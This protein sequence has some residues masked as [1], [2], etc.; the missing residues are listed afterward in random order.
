MTTNKLKLFLLIIL[1]TAVAFS[2]HA[3]ESRW[4]VSAAFIGP[5]DPIYSWWGHVAIIVEDRSSGA[6]RYY[7]YGNFSFDQDSFINNFAM[8]RLYFL[9]MVSNPDPQLRYSSY[10]NRDVTIYKLNIPENRKL[11][12]IR[13]LENDVK[14]ENRIY[15]YDHFYDNCSTRIRDILNTASGGELARAGAA[16]S[17][18]TIR[19]QLRRFTY[20]SPA[21]D[22]LLNFAMKG[23]VDKPASR[24][25]SMFLPN[26]LEDGIATLMIS[27][28]TGGKAP[29]VSTKKIYNQAEGRTAIPELPPTRF[30]IGLI[31]GAL[32]AALGYILL[33]A[34]EKKTAARRAFAVLSSLLSLIFGLAGTLLLF[35]A[36]F[37]DHTFTYWNQNLLFI[38][39]FLLVTLVLSIRLIFSKKAR[40]KSVNICW[41]ITAA[42]AAFSIILKVIPFCRQD[43]LTSI[44]LLL[45][46]A[47]VFSGLLR[48][49][50][51]PA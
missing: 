21:V 46:P 40:I 8:G 6:A 48:N 10:L 33:R 23:N 18:K 22:W 15:L 13:Y 24:W 32:L 47:V 16:D 4:D 27:D 11:E 38:N 36:I 31:A 3:E 17:G 34:A 42:G 30:P 39:P 45:L 5:A 29:F 50:R 12:M 14:P 25:E 20:S 28:E 51:T 19:Q 37:T 2:A 9:K 41:M 7:D 35:M 44:L 49:I 1:L 43:N 26:A